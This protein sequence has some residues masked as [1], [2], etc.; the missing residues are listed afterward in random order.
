MAGPEKKR[1]KKKGENMPIIDDLIEINKRVCQDLWQIVEYP[2]VPTALSPHLIFPEYRQNEIRY[3]EQESRVLYCRQLDRT[4]YFYSIETPTQNQY[5]QSG[6]TDISARSD[7]SLYTIDNNKLDKKANIEFKA[8]NP[9]ANQIGKDL[10]K[11]IKEGL[12]GN[13]FHT[14]VNT[15]KG[16]LPSLF[17]KFKEELV[18]N[19]TTIQPVSVSIVFCFCVLKGKEA[20]IKHLNIGNHAAFHNLGTIL[21]KFFDINNNW[22]VV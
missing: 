3:S 11:L 2:N 12:P 15:D 4:A 14:L 18:H 7:L 22:I 9:R 1:S 6:K 10:E 16:T 17:G 13:W 21:D 19:I 8:H 20:Y 5:R